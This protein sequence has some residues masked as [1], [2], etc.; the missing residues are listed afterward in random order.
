M[1]NLFLGRAIGKH[2][3]AAGALGD[4]R[5]YA[6]AIPTRFDRTADCD[7]AGSLTA[8]KRRRPDANFAW[9]GEYPGLG[10]KAR[11]VIPDGR[12]GL[13]L[14]RTRM[15]KRDG[16]RTFSICRV[17]WTPYTRVRLHRSMTFLTQQ[18]NVKVRAWTRYEPR[19]A[20]LRNIRAAFAGIISCTG[21]KKFRMQRLHIDRLPRRIVLSHNTEDPKSRAG[22]SARSWRWC[23]R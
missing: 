23:Q 1:D 2:F 13:I 17:G 12:L 22:Q 9:P 8:L 14:M 11:P 4:G 10:I 19:P 21:A 5:Q 15:S 18:A 6:T 20:K 7:P 3:D 16:R